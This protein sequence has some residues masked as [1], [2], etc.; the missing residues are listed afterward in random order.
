[1]VRC[2]V[3]GARL[4][5][6]R[7][8]ASLRSAMEFCLGLQARPYVRQVGVL[9]T[10]VAI[11]AAQVLPNSTGQLLT[12]GQLSNVTALHDFSAPIPERWSTTVWG[13]CGRWR[14]IPSTWL[15]LNVG[16]SRWLD[17]TMGE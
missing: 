16:S 10:G 8:P 13:I 3:S 9:P 5:C 2:S 12:C 7:P 11:A 15:C 17:E 4:D 1:M 14:E 6:W